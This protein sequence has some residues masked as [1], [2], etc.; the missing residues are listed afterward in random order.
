MA[1]KKDVIVRFMSTDKDSLQ[2][3]LSILQSHAN[4]PLH[5]E[6]EGG[7][8][9]GHVT[10]IGRYRAG[11]AIRPRRPVL[12][13]DAGAVGFQRLTLEERRRRLYGR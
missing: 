8:D 6:W 10:A 7:H 9:S 11:G 2:E 5:V 3:V 12:V 13:H 1:R 4:L